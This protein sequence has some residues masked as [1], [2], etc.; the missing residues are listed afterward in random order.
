[1]PRTKDENVTCPRKQACFKLLAFIFFAQALASKV[2]TDSLRTELQRVRVHKGHLLVW[3]SYLQQLQKF[4]S[5]VFELRKGF[6]LSHPVSKT[7]CIRHA[8]VL[9]KCRNGICAKHW[10][11]IAVLLSLLHIFKSTLGSVMALRWQMSVKCTEV[12]DN[13]FV[14]LGPLSA[15]CK[16]FLIR[17]LLCKDARCPLR[18]V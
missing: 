8:Q 1:M 15:Q 5:K 6:L 18:I 14:I 3:F 12:R 4:D 13:L 11:Y 17:L 7:G 2:C 10:H 16:S 9:W